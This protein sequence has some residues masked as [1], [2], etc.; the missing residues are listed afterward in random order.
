MKIW[1]DA[2]L[3]PALARWLTDTLTDVGAYSASYLGLRDASDRDIF[4]VART[5]NTI[6][7]TKDSDFISLVEKLRPPLIVIW[8][9]CGN[10]SNTHLKN[11][12][13]PPFEQLYTY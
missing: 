11:Y 13:L 12:Y 3:S 2:Q 8:I 9:T 6:V 10:T 5:E 1:I 7:M 4:T